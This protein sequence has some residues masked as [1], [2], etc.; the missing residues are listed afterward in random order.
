MNWAL[1]SVSIHEA[2]HIVT[3]RAL[4]VPCNEAAIISDADGYSTSGAAAPEQKLMVCLG[5]PLAEMRACGAVTDSAVGGDLKMIATY[6]RRCGVNDRHIEALRHK[7][8]TLLFQHWDKVEAVAAAL[9][10]HGTLSG[11]DIDFLVRT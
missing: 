8:R 11:A 1:R 6:A 9:A 10:K 5:G 7:V 2:G 3:A 4:G